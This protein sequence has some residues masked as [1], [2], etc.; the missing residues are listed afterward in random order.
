MDVLCIG[1]AVIDITGY[2]IGPGKLWKEKQRISEIRILAGGDAANQSL[3]LAALGMHPALA[4]CIGG[5]TN[6]NILQNTLR[7][8]GVETNY[9]RTKSQAATGTALV[10][11]DEDGERRTFS[12]KG[13]HSLITASDLPAQLPAECRA[14]S[15]ASLFS[16][17]ELEK[18]GLENYLCN[19]KS[20]AISI[21]ADLASDKLG[22]GLD[23]IRPFLPYIDYFMPSLYDV[24]PMTHTDSPEAAAQVFRSLGVRHVLIKCGADGC[25]CCSDS[26]CGWIPAVPVQPVD[27]TGAG[28]CFCA[29]FISQILNQRPLADACR[30]A[31][32]AASYSTLFPGASQVILSEEKIMECMR[33]AQPSQ[34]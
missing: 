13:A 15:L 24:L 34:P 23:G 8:R 21:F 3:H 18:N 17:P 19:T 10:L 22:L 31:C 11:V 27:T 30:Y 2:P 16:M 20:K 26:F 12:V 1:S 14:I 6:G 32:A 9:L 29:A 7:D 28:D 33:I 25:Y 4:A 5:D